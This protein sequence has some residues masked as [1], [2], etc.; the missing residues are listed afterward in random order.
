VS[1]QATEDDVLFC[2]IAE[3]LLLDFI[4]EY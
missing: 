3:D 4:D 1:F 2:S